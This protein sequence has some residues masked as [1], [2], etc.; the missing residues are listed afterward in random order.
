[1]CSAHLAAWPHTWWGNVWFC[2]QWHFESSATDLGWCW[3][4]GSSPV[5][6]ND[7]SLPP[8]AS[9]APAVLYA[10]LPPDWTRGV[11][12]WIEPSPFHSSRPSGWGMILL[13]LWS[14]Y[15]QHILWNMMS[16]LMLS[17]VATFLIICQSRHSKQSCS[18]GFIC[19]HWSK[20]WCHSEMAGSETVLV[21]T[22]KHTFTALFSQS[23]LNFSCKNEV[24]IKA[25][26]TCNRHCATKVQ[27]RESDRNQ[28]KTRGNGRTFTGWRALQ[29][30]VKCRPFK[31][32]REL[33]SIVI[34][35]VYIPPRAN[36]K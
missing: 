24:W 23:G 34:I 15:H 30:C 7:E 3:G 25:Q 16:R 12:L 33:L 28:C 27:M 8:P 22:I 10:S 1:M 4:W 29:C 21:Y 19:S 20:D 35:A 13:S 11:R 14:S 36:A 17:W 32:V 9:F 5:S 26:R 18:W 31:L 2:S 6:A